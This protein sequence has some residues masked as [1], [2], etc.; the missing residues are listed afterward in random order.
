VAAKEA[1][2]G[3]T[4]MASRAKTAASQKKGGSYKKL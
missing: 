2:P 4:E 3:L 1:K